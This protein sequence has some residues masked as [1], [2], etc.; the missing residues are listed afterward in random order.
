M[1]VCRQVELLRRKERNEAHLYMAVEVYL[2]DDF[3]AHQNSDLLD[4]E[5]VKARC[6]WS[7]PCGGNPQPK[8]LVARSFRVLKTQSL[9]VFQKQLAEHLVRVY[10]L[11]SH[12]R[13]MTV[14]M[15]QGYPEN[16]I[17]LWPFEKRSNYTCRPTFV[18]KDFTK[19]VRTPSPLSS[20]QI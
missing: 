7:Y 5:E 9:S 16:H 8:F 19:S 15:H 1:H 18:D 10:L 14:C 3:Q 2:E 17:R 11:I 12:G 20:S 13:S 6:V 4:F